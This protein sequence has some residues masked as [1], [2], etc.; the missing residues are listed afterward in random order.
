MG[1][2]QFFNW[3]D[4]FKAASSKK[5]AYD[6]F[7]AMAGEAVMGAPGSLIGQTIIPGASALWQ[8]DYA[9]AKEKLAPKAFGM[10][11]LMAAWNYHN[12]GVVDT[13]GNTTVKPKDISY[14]ELIR[15]SLGFEP[16]EISE[17]KQINRNLF[18][19]DQ[20][21]T[22]AK[23]ALI[24]EFSEA[25]MAKDFKAREA[26]MKDIMRW[27]RSNPGYMIT[28]SSLRQ[29]V[30]YRQKGEYIVAKYGANVRTRGQRAVLQELEARYGNQ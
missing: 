2:P 25:R 30:R 21:L 23:Q 4:M 9:T 18:A 8:G 5:S 3:Q 26:A 27:N 12:R 17:R 10:Q 13:R 22:N 28:R 16:P 11:D 20:K 15:K 14:G 1:L 29:A 24:A 7:A 19:K 6:S